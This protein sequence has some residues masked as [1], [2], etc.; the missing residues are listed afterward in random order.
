MDFLSLTG[1]S[2]VG[3]LVLLIP[4][5]YLHNQLLYSDIFVLQILRKVSEG[6]DWE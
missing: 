3:K 6:K 1:N 2:D 5:R 4:A